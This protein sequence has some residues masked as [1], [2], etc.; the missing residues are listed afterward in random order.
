MTE[1]IE[2]SKFAK[3]IANQRFGRLIALGPVGRIDRDILWLCQ[4]DCGNTL[5]VRCT[6]LRKGNTSSCGCRK[7]E[8]HTARLKTHGLRKNKLYNTWSGMIQRCENPKHPRFKDWG[9][10]GISVATEWRHNFQSFFDH[11]SILDHCGEKGYSLDRVNN[12]GNYEPGNVRWATHQEQANN[13]RRW[14]R[15]KQ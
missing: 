6:S 11:V 2:L 7:L 14:K 3:N 8:M 13:S 9:G 12:N 10:R 5:S 1:F 4:C 15:E